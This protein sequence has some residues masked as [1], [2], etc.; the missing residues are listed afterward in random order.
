M[1]FEIK[2]DWEEIITELVGTT[3]DIPIRG[4]GVQKKNLQEI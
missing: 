4:A 2:E 3:V 1:Y